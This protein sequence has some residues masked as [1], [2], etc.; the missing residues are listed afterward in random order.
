MDVDR[1]KLIIDE[2]ES[3][4][5]LVKKILREKNDIIEDKKK[6]E[7]NLRNEINKLCDENQKI[8]NELEAIKNSRSYKLTQ[9]VKRV[10]GR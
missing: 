6:D 7:E 5:E 3:E 8:Y 1:N 9:K 2:L 10:L 4:L